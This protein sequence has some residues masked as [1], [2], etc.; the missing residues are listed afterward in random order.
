MAKTQSIKYSILAKDNTGR[1]IQLCTTDN[2]NSAEYV[3]QAL[4]KS[5]PKWHL[6]LW[7]RFGTK[8][9]EQISI[10]EGAKK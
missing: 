8:K 3:M 2:S 6:E 10:R 9:E 1:L 4:C 7:S 5:Y